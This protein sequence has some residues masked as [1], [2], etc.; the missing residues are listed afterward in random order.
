M[1]KIKFYLAFLVAGMY[2]NGYSQACCI[3]NHDG[4]VDC[5]DPVAQKDC[6]ITKPTQDS[7]KFLPTGKCWTGMVLNCPTSICC[8]GKTCM[9]ALTKAQCDQSGGNSTW[10]PVGT[11]ALCESSGRIINLASLKGMY[12]QQDQSVALQWEGEP[13]I[14]NAGFYIERSRDGVIFKIIGYVDA[15]LVNGGG[16]AFTDINPFMVSYYR[17]S[18]TANGGLVYSQTIPVV[19]VDNGQLQLM[20]NPASSKMRPMPFMRLTAKRSIS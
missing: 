17:L 2:M 11:C 5:A 9:R 14:D 19:A 16:F 7:I 12:S 4:S 20:P 13:V 3:Y 1:K 6:N 18:G 15:A 10:H 8:R